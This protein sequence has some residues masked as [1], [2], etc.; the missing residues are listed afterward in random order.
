MKNNKANVHWGDIFYCDL[1][2][3]KGSVQS[4]MRPVI[5]VQ[6]ERLNKKSPTAVV[7]VLT[8][9]KKKPEMTSH[10]LVGKECGLAEPSMILLEQLRTIDVEKELKEYI[11]TVKDKNTINEIKRGLK[12]AVGIPMRPRLERKALI[13]CLC[14]DCRDEFYNDNEHI[15]RRM[16]PFQAEKYCCEK[17]Q[18]NYGYDYVISKKFNR[19]EQ[20]NGNE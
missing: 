5:I 18:I 9:V 15:V 14:P 13:L 7:A 3:N 10:V 2:A 20:D 17:C 16:D 1:G 19:K 12:Y 4:G 8:T 11:G 6:T